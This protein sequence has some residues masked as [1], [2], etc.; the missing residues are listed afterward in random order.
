MLAV[1]AAITLAILVA[2]F[3][4]AHEHGR[5]LTQREAI[6]ARSIYGDTIDLSRVHLVFDSVYATFAPVTLGNTIHVNSSWTRSPT[7]ADLSEG[8]SAHHV[9]LHELAHVAQYQHDGWSYLMNSLLAQSYAFLSKGSRDEAYRWE[10][11]VAEGTPYES[12]NPEEQAQGIA[13]FEYYVLSGN[14]EGTLRA[15]HAE[16]LGCAIPLF[17]QGYCLSR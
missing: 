7:N 14:G 12:W 17:R 9:L 11:R 10:E 5:D 16:S 1:F 2:L 13:D 6:L 3:I 4:G 8:P 15:K